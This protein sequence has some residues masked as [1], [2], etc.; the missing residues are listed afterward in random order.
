MRWHSPVKGVLAVDG[1]EGLRTEEDGEDGMQP[2]PREVE[3]VLKLGLES[4]GYGARRAR[5][6]GRYSEWEPYCQVCACLVSIL[7]RLSN[8]HIH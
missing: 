1:M 8:C 3:D 2:I 7:R 5:R 6:H 4:A